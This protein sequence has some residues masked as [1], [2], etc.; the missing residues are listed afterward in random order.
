MPPSDGSRAISVL[1]DWFLSD[2]IAEGTWRGSGHPSAVSYWAGQRRDVEAQDV[3]VTTRVCCCRDVRARVGLNREGR[4]TQATVCLLPWCRADGQ[5][6]PAMQD[7]QAESE[8]RRRARY[9]RDSQAWHGSRLFPLA[10]DFMCS[11]CQ[12][13][14]YEFESSAFEGMASMERLEWLRRMQLQGLSGEGD[15]GLVRLVAEHRRSR[16]R[17][18]AL[19]IVARCEAER[20]SGSATGFLKFLQLLED[21]TFSEAQAGMG[22]RAGAGG[23]LRG[24]QGPRGGGGIPESGSAASA[25]H[26]SLVV[27]RRG[28]VRLP[29]CLGYVFGATGSCAGGIVVRARMGAGCGRLCGRVARSATS[30]FGSR[31]GIRSLVSSRR[32]GCAVAF[33]VVAAGGCCA[34]CAVFASA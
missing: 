14:F 6:A 2:P 34:C 5:G 15:F 3:M 8:E 27:A 16:V 17:Q 31:G 30:A 25:R 26:G 23:I 7:V 1:C 29:D 19:S 22:G 28:A 10:F 33:S 9:E 21:D 18:E 4:P 11:A 24:V 13:E 20:C 32:S 12:R